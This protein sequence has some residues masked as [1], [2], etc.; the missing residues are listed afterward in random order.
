MAESKAALWCRGKVG[1]EHTPVVRREGRTLGVLGSCHMVGKRWV[2]VHHVECEVCGRV[3][4]YEWQMQQEDCPD[5]DS[6]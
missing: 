6:V 2:C 3:M 5:A 4:V 1:R